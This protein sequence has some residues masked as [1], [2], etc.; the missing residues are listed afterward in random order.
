MSFSA[1]RLAYRR[2]KLDAKTNV[3]VTPEVLPRLMCAASPPARGLRPRGP[4]RH[5][6]NMKPKCCRRKPISIRTPS[7]TSCGVQYSCQL[8]KGKPN[9]AF[10]SDE[11]AN[12]S[13][14][15][16]LHPRRRL[17]TRG[18]RCK[19]PSR[20][21]SAGSRSSAAFPLAGRVRR[22]QAGLESA[23]QEWDVNIRRAEDTTT[24]RLLG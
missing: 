20:E 1:T 3:M 6:G 10:D 17:V 4:G 7:G 24:L 18:A 9:R 8:T 19:S 5:T 15:D 12:G 11:R 2:L 22:R 16:G 21:S 23:R 13:P 14:R